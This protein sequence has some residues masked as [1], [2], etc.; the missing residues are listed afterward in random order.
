MF[1]QGSKPLLSNF[2][3]IFYGVICDSRT[4][5]FHV[6]FSKTPCLLRYF[7]QAL[8]YV[9]QDRFCC[10]SEMRLLVKF[11]IPGRCL[12]CWGRSFRCAGSSSLSDSPSSSSTKPGNRNIFAKLTRMHVRGHTQMWIYQYS[13]LL[14]RIL[15]VA[16]FKTAR[17][18]ESQLK[19]KDRYTW[20]ITVNKGTWSTCHTEAE[21]KN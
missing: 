21:A 4:Q 20:V 12:L 10:I 2:I 1:G 9:A 8:W 16:R 19:M 5:M 7:S 11:T 15:V 18:V 13:L 17:E 3:C 14:K 6:L